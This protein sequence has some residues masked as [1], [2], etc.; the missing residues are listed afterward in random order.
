MA[1]YRLPARAADRAK[2][3]LSDADL[4]VPDPIGWED[5]GL[6][7]DP[8]YVEA[9]ATGTLPAAMQRRIGFPWSPEMVERRGVRS[10][11]RSPRP[12]DALAGGTIAANLAGGTHHAF[13]DRGEGY[14]VFNDVAVAARVLLRDGAIAHAVVVDCD[15][16]RAT[17][18]PRFSG[19]T[20]RCSPL[21]LHGANNFPFRKEESDLDITFP[22]GTGDDEYLAALRTSCRACSTSSGR[23]SSSTWPAPTRMPAIGSAGSG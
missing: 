9:V 2:A 10:G 20:R 23:T 15:V 22:D 3:V 5:C 11:R 1:K 21:S 13:R 7:H 6:A 12:A 4:V 8:A 17:A 18:P 16:H 19:A 14:C